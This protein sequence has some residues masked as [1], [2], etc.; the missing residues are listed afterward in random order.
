MTLRGAVPN[1]QTGCGI[2]FIPLSEINDPLAESDVSYRKAAIVSWVET[3]PTIAN[4]AVAHIRPVPWGMP[5]ISKFAALQ[6][7]A[8]ISMP[9]GHCALR[10]FE[11]RWH[12]RVIYF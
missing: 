5:R 1:G 9:T 3:L 12:Q 10:C 2:G 8:G 4:A 6:C 11:I 7:P